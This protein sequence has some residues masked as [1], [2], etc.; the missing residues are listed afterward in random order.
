MGTQGSPTPAEPIGQLFQSDPTEI[1]CST[2][3]QK[4]KA[5]LAMIEPEHPVRNT[6]SCMV[7]TLDPSPIE[8]P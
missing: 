7:P 8:H 2:N 6:L 4:K 3:R 1:Q 5:V